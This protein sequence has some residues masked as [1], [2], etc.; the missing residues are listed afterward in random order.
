MP[1]TDIGF[2]VRGNIT[3]FV[4]NSWVGNLFIIHPVRAE[5]RN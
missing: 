3:N 2:E 1:T 5:E 4:E